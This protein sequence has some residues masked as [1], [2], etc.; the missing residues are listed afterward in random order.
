LRIPSLSLTRPDPSGVLGRPDFVEAAPAEPHRSTGTTASSFT[1]P[2]RRPGDEGLSPPSGPPAP[3]GALLSRN[4][5]AATE[6][7]APYTSTGSPAPVCVGVAGR[8][9]ILIS[10]RS[11]GLSAERWNWLV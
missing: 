3:R 1:P 4:N 6:T 10:Q 8:P 11:E 2:L 7:P 9:L 5:P